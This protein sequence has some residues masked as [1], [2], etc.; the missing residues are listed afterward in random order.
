M[1]VCWYLRLGVRT[2]QPSFFNCSRS[3]C[4]ISRMRDRLRDSVRESA[5]SK[6][7]SRLTFGVSSHAH[8][9]VQAM[10]A[11]TLVSA[12]L[13]R[14]SRYAELAAL[15][16]S[17]RSRS[18]GGGPKESSSAFNALANLLSWSPHPSLRQQAIPKRRNRSTDI[19]F[20]SFRSNS[21]MTPT[22]RDTDTAV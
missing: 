8:T 18:L 13:L 11:S 21:T 7:P 6:L 10:S 22:R 15:N 9:S 1:F 14:M 3:S 12:Y 5:D 2:H 16:A 20:N 19:V 17:R 4:S